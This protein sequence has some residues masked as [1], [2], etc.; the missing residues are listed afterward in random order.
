MQTGASDA[1]RGCFSLSGSDRGWVPGAGRVFVVSAGVFPSGPGCLSGAS[2]MGGGTTSVFV[3]LVGVVQN[4]YE[5]Q[6]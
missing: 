4:A 6:R 1:S 2:R 3:A 5:A